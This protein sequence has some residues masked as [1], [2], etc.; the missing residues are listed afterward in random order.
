MN[1][2]FLQGKVVLSYNDPKVRNSRVHLRSDFPNFKEE[3]SI[4]TTHILKDFIWLLSSIKQVMLSWT[5]WRWQE[6]VLRARWTH[7]YGRRHVVCTHF[8]KVP[9]KNTIVEAIEEE[10]N[11]KVHGIF[12]FDP[13]KEVAWPALRHDCFVFS[14]GHSRRC[15]KVEGSRAR[16]SVGKLRPNLACCIYIVCGHQLNRLALWASKMKPGYPFLPHFPPLLP[17]PASS[18]W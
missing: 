6:A 10:R 4:H 1:A 12:W 14:L 5:L 17:V 11:A 15:L 7:P 13:V 2:N 3:I 9:L 18:N 16:A 8:C